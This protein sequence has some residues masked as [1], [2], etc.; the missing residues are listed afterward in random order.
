M[1]QNLRIDFEKLIADRR[2]A[3]FASGA[4]TRTFRVEKPQSA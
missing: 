3:R 4:A 2:A 1:K